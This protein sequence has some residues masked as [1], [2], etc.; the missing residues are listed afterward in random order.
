VRTTVAIDDNL[1]A[2]AR[3]RARER[4]T[5][6]GRVLEDALRRDLAAQDRPKGPPIPVFKGTG[7]QPGVDL[8]SNRAMYEA[9]DE[10]VS[11]ENL[12]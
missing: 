2:A 3:E 9:L 12:R 1:L 7:V 5:T 4:G 8:S 6:L 11:L 10:G